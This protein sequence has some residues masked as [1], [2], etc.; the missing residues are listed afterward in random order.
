[1]RLLELIAA[2]VE[3]R[4]EDFRF[5][6]RDVREHT[7][8]GH[9]QLRVHLDRLAEMEYLIVHQGGRGQSFVYEYDGRLAGSEDQLA[10]AKRPQNGGVAATSRGN[11]TRINTAPNGVFHEKPEKRIA[12][13]A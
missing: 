9:T 8:W 5:S 2:M 3:G 4:G 13:G 7:G 12:T 11:E 6:R 10:G 1:R